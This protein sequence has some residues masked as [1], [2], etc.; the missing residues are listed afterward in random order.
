MVDKAVFPLATL[1]C[2]AREGAATLQTPTTGNDAEDAVDGRLRVPWQEILLQTHLSIRIGGDPSAA[3]S[4]RVFVPPEL[5]VEAMDAIAPAWRSAPWINS[6]TLTPFSDAVIRRLRADGP[7]WLGWLRQHLFFAK[8]VYSAFV[9]NAPPQ[10]LVDEARNWAPCVNKFEM[11]EL[12]RVLRSIALDKCKVATSCDWR[13]VSYHVILR[14]PGAAI[15]C[16]S[17]SSSDAFVAVDAHLTGD[18]DDECVELGIHYQ[19]AVASHCRRE[20]G[21]AA[22][23]SLRQALQLFEIGAARESAHYTFVLAASGAS[24]PS[25]QPKSTTVTVSSRVHLYEFASLGG[26]LGRALRI[27]AALEGLVTDGAL[28]SPAVGVLVALCAG[29]LALPLLLPAWLL[30]R[31]RRS[32]TLADRSGPSG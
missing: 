3:P 26:F 29:P 20:S 4:S 12:S 5:S 6:S 22:E 11:G 14:L 31:R 19:G 30:L 24:P 9:S 17:R 21:G 27:K 2:M 28:S 16:P 25:G 32:R 7:S 23:T 13:E 8:A 10:E 15:G 18:S 1:R